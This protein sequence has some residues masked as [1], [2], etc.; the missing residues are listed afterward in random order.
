[1]NQVTPKEAFR[2]LVARYERREAE[3]RVR[4]EGLRAAV[5][6]AVPGL[7][8]AAGASE[9]WLFGSLVG[10]PEWAEPHE[11]S[12]ID[13]AIAGLDAAAFGRLAGDL[14]AALPVPADI[15]DLERADAAMQ[16][17]ILAHGERVYARDADA[18]A[19]ST[20]ESSR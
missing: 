2:T 15:A 9:V 12:D 1:V 11:R 6:A 16:G 4:A 13:L 17:R 5:R 14:F 8:A 18:D 19:E 7:A 20:A 10:P 3:A